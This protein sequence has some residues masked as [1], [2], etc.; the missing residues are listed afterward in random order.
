MGPRVGTVRLEE[1]LHVRQERGAWV[2]GVGLLRG[3]VQHG[4]LEV[5][6][7]CREVDGEPLCGEEQGQV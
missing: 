7:W 3:H 4:L 2:Q 1:R 6:L 5:W